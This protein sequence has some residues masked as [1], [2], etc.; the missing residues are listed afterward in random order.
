MKVTFA[1]ESL[2][3]NATAFLS[4]VEGSSLLCTRC[5][6]RVAV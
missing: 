1:C 4:I 6:S 5:C 2:R 3:K